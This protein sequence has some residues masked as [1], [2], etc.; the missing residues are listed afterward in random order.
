MDVFV[1]GSDQ[2]SVR[3]ARVSFGKDEKVDPERDKKL[4]RYLFRHR[5]ASPF[6]HNIIAFRA[7]KE[8][9]LN[10]LGELENP[11]VQIYYSG[12]Y[13]W[14]NLRSA[15]NSLNYL[16][17]ELTEVLEEHFPTTWTIVRKMERWRMMSSLP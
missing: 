10:V 14:L 15:I 11:T 16:P 4:L 9:W 7:D 17:Q 2:R 6:E 1:M 13:I 12:G 3:C 5:H 8:E